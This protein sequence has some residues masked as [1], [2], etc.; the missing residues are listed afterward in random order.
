MRNHLR[1][2]ALGLAVT[3]CSGAAVPSQQAAVSQAIVTP[4]A[5]LAP[6]AKPSAKPTAEPTPRPTPT[7]D[8][9]L[10]YTV[11]TETFGEDLDFLRTDIAEAIEADY[12]WVESIDRT[13]Y[14]PKRN[15]L[16]WDATVAYDLVYQ[17]DPAE[18]RAD[19]WELYRDFARDV[20]TAIMEGVGS[21][22]EFEPDWARWTP[23]LRLDGNGGRLIVDC[24]GAF[25]FAL[26]QRVAT[27]DDYRKLCKFKT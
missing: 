14:D 12:Y 23:R 8:P 26:S 6:T 18:W 4:T 24:P 22:I 2:V 15:M 13:S 5:T 16:R 7:T 17:N 21:S 10:A 20:W 25:M 1:I 11:W 9:E 27:Q 19:T 3:A